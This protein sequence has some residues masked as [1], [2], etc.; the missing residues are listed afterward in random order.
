MQKLMIKPNNPCFGSGPVRKPKKWDIS[1]IDTK[2][3]GQSHRSQTGIKKIEEVVNATRDALLIPKDYHV[4]LLVGSATAAMEAALWNL[5]GAADVRIFDFDTFSKRWADDITHQL[6]PEK[7]VHIDTTPFGKN[8]LLEDKNSQEDLLFCLNGSTSG[9]LIQSFDWLLKEREGLVFCDA[10]S[11]AYIAPIPF[12]NLDVVAFSYQKGLGSE[13]SLGCLV[14][15]PKAYERLNSYSP[16]WPIPRILRLKDGHN[17]AFSAKLL[18]TPSLL[19][20]E[21]ILFCHSIY[22]RDDALQTAKNNRATFN[23]CLNES[24]IF[25]PIVK[26]DVF[27]SYCTGVFTISKDVFLNKSEADQR[28]ILSKMALLLKEESV[29]FDFVNHLEQPPSLRIWL[30]PTMDETDIKKLFPW[31]EAAFFKSIEDL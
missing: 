4:A 20:L 16:K 26:N 15:S 10:T 31:L 2:I 21:E 17:A 3:L 12:L 27:Q 23:H 1:L 22:D 6:K 28:M 13:A 18:N 11:A 24:K 25:S 30:G 7:T 29:A 8:P 5:I 14:L 19:V 9:I